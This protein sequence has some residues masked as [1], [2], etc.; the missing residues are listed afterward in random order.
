MFCFD[1]NHR[2]EEDDDM[3]EMS[4]HFWWVRAKKLNSVPFF[5]YWKGLRKIK[6][7]N[8]IYTDRHTGFKLP[9]LTKRKKDS[10]F[11]M[12]KWIKGK[13]SN[14]ILST[15][16]ISF[17]HLYFFGFIVRMKL[18]RAINIS[19]KSKQHH[20][21][22][23]ILFFLASFE[24]IITRRI[25]KLFLLWKLIKMQEKQRVRANVRI[26]LILFFKDNISLC[27]C[28][29]IFVHMETED[30]ESKLYVRI[31]LFSP[32]LSAFAFV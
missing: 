12:G 9:N 18:K 15:C 16:F 6:R 1:A 25:W 17:S 20:Y 7:M 4:C 31:F 29:M 21:K 8:K 28:K 19:M 5:L 32:Q 3:D 11:L 23:K 13:Q 14:N 22:A 2:K 26:N 30:H 27:R 24:K 10:Y